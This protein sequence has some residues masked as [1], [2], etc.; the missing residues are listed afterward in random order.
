MFLLFTRVIALLSPFVLWPWDLLFGESMKALKPGKYF[1][2]SCS[3]VNPINI[4]RYYQ[5]RM[6]QGTKTEES[7]STKA[8]AVSATAIQKEKIEQSIV[9]SL[10]QI[11]NRDR[12]ELEQSLARL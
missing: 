8:A 4:E 7:I 2:T 3:R 5:S 1:S 12:K 11:T 6:Q 10:V 9:E